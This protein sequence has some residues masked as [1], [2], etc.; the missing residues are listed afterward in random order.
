M[1][2]VAGRF[3]VFSWVTLCV[4]W[5]VAAFSTRRT[6]Q[7]YQWSRWWVL[8][9]LA[10]GALVFS[11]PKGIGVFRLTLWSVAPVVGFVA[12]IRSPSDGFRHGAR[13]KTGTVGLEP[14]AAM[15]RRHMTDISHGNLVIAWT[16]NSG[17]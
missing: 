2:M 6:A 10:V 11:R 15:M 16:G 4:V 7:R 13:D 12:D 9:V 5:V 14:H 17:L 3:I 1:D 8:L